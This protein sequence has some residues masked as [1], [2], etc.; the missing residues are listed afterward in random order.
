MDRRIGGSIRERYFGRVS[1][2]FNLTKICCFFFISN[3]TFRL[4]IIRSFRFSTV[5][6]FYIPFLKQYECLKKLLQNIYALVQ[7]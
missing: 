7:M 6:T 4:L 1:M 5:D 2:N 3:N